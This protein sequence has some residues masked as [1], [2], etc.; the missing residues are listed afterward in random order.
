MATC[1]S[2]LPF[3]D[4]T[5]WLISCDNGSTMT[6]VT[7]PISRSVAA[8]FGFELRLHRYFFLMGFGVLTDVFLNVDQPGGQG[9]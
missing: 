1:R 9:D 5:I 8:D 6:F 7:S 4:T 2:P 3:I